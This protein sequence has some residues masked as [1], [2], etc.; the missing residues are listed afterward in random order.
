MSQADSPLR[1]CFIFKIWAS[2]A[3]SKY[4]DRLPPTKL[5]SQQTSILSSRVR[6]SPPLI[7]VLSQINPIHAFTLVS[8]WPFLILPCHM[9]QQC[10]AGWTGGVLFRAGARDFFLWNLQTGS[11]SH[12]VSYP[13]VTA[14]S[15]PRG[16]TAGAWSWPPYV[17]MTWQLI[18]HRDNFTFFFVTF[19]SDHSLARVMFPAD[20][21]SKF[22]MHFS[23]TCWMC[24]PSSPTCP[25]FY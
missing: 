24:C 17:Y 13:M 14:G 3:S 4:Q 8:L 25:Q 20:F 7:P 2:I 19:R 10:A 23:Y 5:T 21:G 9:L 1:S 12:L 16:K 6:K 15:F 11:G 22:F 18:K